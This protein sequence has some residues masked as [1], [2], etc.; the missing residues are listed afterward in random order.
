M[1][2]HPILIT[3]FTDALVIEFLSEKE[4]QDKLDFFKRNKPDP[5]DC[6]PWSISWAGKWSDITIAEIQLARVDLNIERV[7]FIGA[8]IEV[9]ATWTKVLDKDG[10][11]YGTYKVN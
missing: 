6:P 3:R 7:Q 11:W 8:E 9:P 1:N 5:R 10:K 4:I 2:G